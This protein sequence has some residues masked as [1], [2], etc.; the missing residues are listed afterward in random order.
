M[1]ILQDVIAVLPADSEAAEFFRNLEEQRIQ[2]E[3]EV[4]ERIR[5]SREELE[6]ED[7]DSDFEADAE[8]PPAELLAQYGRV[9]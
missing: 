6:A 3:R 7:D 4:A 1:S 2:G 5:R 9:A 8:A